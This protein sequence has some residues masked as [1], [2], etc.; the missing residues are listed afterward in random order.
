M[1]LCNHN[2]SM[3]VNIAWLFYGGI[4][5]SFKNSHINFEY[6]VRKILT[7]GTLRFRSMTYFLP[8][9]HERNVFGEIRFEPFENIDD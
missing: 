1:Y 6:L 3:S 4:S 2:D 9:V 8:F 5:S 7:L